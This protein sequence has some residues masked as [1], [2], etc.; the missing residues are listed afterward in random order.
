MFRI[1]SIELKD[2][3]RHHHIKKSLDGHLIGLA[4]PNGA[5]KTT[6]LQAIQWVLT[7]NIDAKD[8]ISAWI[9]RTSDGNGPSSMSGTIEFESDGKKGTISRKAT[10]TSQTRKLTFEGLLD[11]KG[12]PTIL[13]SDADVSAALFQILGVDKKA[14]NTTV[15]IKQGE[16]GKLFG[17]DT[18]RRE[19]Y[20][21]LMML[22]SL[23]KIGDITEG[24]RKQ[25]GGSIQDLSA[26]KDAADRVYE[27][28]LSQHEA[29]SSELDKM[30]DW[31]AEQQASN[32]LVALISA[33]LTADQAYEDA[34]RKDVG[35]EAELAGRSVAQF[36]EQWRSKLDTARCGL[37][38]ANA[39]DSLY[40]SLDRE[41]AAFQKRVELTIKLGEDIARLV[42]LSQQRAVYVSA[43][44]RDHPQV[45]IDSCN[46]KLAARA[47][48]KEILPLTSAASLRLS[49]ATV[50]AERA[51]GGMSAQEAIWRQHNKTHQT[52]TTNYQL[53]KELWDEVSKSQNCDSAQCV[54]CGGAANIKFL[55]KSLK[56]SEELM[57]RSRSEVD[58]STM[59]GA[60]ARQAQKNSERELASAQDEEARL[61]KELSDLKIAMA[62]M[63]S[64][65]SLNQALLDAQEALTRYSS[66][67]AHLTH[68]DEEVR[69]LGLS[70]RVPDA[71]SLPELQA[72]LAKSVNDLEACNKPDVNLAKRSACASDV[73]TSEE[74]L[75]FLANNLEQSRK[76]HEA[77]AN[78]VA[79]A[80]AHLKHVEVAHPTLYQLLSKE[81]IDHAFAMTVAEDVGKRQE[82][83]VEQRGKMSASKLSLDGASGAVEELD[84]RIAEQKSRMLLE[85]RLKRVRDAFKPAGVTTEFLDYKFNRIAEMATNYLAEAGADFIVAASS[86]SPLSYDF[87]RTDRPDEAWLSQSRLSGGQRVRLAIATLRAIHALI[88]PNVGLLVLDEPTTHLDDVAKKSMAEMLRRIGE[89]ETLQ[90]IICDHDPVLID[91]FSDVIEIPAP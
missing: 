31:S 64:T 59:N 91:A 52:A 7:G 42:E 83:F 51:N 10:M 82:T 87:L 66:A 79:A 49:A 32:Q 56:Y 55:E 29:Y 36:Q 8:P 30:R 86:D 44:A 63:P 73:K 3:G 81:I 5:G 11:D 41:V 1:K 74:Q 4:A 80:E 40:W 16:I 25:V 68:I 15:F 17:L 27:E 62:D 90:M 58:A 6:V 28:A 20:T 9:R 76:A 85:E 46:S 88:M 61:G 26:L 24:F 22:G 47:R 43:T 70:A 57:T 33:S 72:A 13:T 50:E 53:R 60:L 21:K 37:A 75:E 35:L 23:D 19:F 78:A 34:R 84:L 54:V 38:E 67:A 14:I 39:A 18:E 69:R 65:D 77:Q 71:L 89:E 12:K 45:I 2:V 48:A